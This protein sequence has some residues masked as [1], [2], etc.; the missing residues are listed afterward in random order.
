MGFE[1][2]M[3]GVRGLVLSLLDASTWSLKALTQTLNN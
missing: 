1:V 2:S 3:K